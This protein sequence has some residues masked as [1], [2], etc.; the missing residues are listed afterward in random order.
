MTDRTV[1]LLFPTADAEQPQAEQPACFVD[2]NL[3]QLVATLSGEKDPFELLP[4]LHTPA[5]QPQTVAH[6]H[7][8][9]RDLE[10]PAIESAVDAFLK[11][12][13]QVA[14]E[15]GRSGESYH[16]HAKSRW[17]LDAL[18]TYCDAVAAFAD[19]LQVGK[20]ASDGFRAF[21]GY[22]HD[23][24]AGD[25]FQALRT[26][27]R[28]R[29]EELASIRYDLLMNGL[30]VEV[31]RHAEQADYGREIAATFARFQSGKADQQRHGIP[32][33]SS[34]QHPLRDDYRLNRVEENVLTQLVKLFPELF[35]RVDAYVQ[36]WAGYAD[37]VVMRVARELQFFLRYRQYIAPLQKAGQPFC[38]PA[39]C[40]PGERIA[41]EHAC[42]LVLAHQLMSEGRTGVANDFNLDPPERLLLVSGP[43]QGGKTTFAR[44]FGQLHYL[45]RLGLPVPARSATLL[46]WHGLYTHFERSEDI[47]NLRGKLEDDL[48]RIHAILQDVDAAGVVIMNEIF[49]STTTDDARYLGERILRRL[50]AI[51]ATGVCVTFID[52]LALLGPAI[53]SMASTV[54]PADPAIRTFHVVRKPPDGKAYARALAAKH[55]LTRADLEARL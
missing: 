27:T 41:A 17:L 50:L 11:G 54:D 23:Y 22:L 38:Y 29:L 32:T 7:A 15:R 4:L 31:S 8:V 9:F 42:D 43:N 49:S 52:D 33:V 45:A 55:H 40:Q 2:L 34:R 6:R 1:S 10:R 18:K 24:V 39:F 37:A 3:D 44:M 53:V 14:D 46:W 47:R 21:A 35:A 20:P 51:G 25:E 19:M 13:A 12:L 5:R 28:D 36:R 48:V 30:R 16:P 26:A